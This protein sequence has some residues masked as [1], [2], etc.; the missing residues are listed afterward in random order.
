MNQH[1]EAMRLESTLQDMGDGL[2]QRMSGFLP[3]NTVCRWLLRRRTTRLHEVA[4]DRESRSCG[5]YPCSCIQ[6]R[7]DPKYLLLAHPSPRPRVMPLFARDFH[8]SKGEQG[9][10]G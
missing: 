8:M 10:P 4:P 5:V 3:K 2:E 1:V 9:E 7:Q 6:G